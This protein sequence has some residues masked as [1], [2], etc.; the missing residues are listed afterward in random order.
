MNPGQFEFWTD[1]VF[2]TLQ[3]PAIG[4]GID[5]YD[6]VDVFGEVAGPYSYATKIGG[7]N[8]VP[9]ISAKYMTLVEK[10]DS[11]IGN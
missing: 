3:D 7:A 11:A 10:R 2:V 9:A 6:I 8:T 5:Q 4:S 1:P